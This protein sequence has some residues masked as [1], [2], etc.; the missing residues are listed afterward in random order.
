MKV[1]DDIFHFG[2]VDG[3]LGACTPRI[4]C[5]SIVGEY[6]DEIQ[7]IEIAEFKGS[8]VFYPPAHDKM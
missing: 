3:A 4:L 8:R 7:R 2:I 6:A 5:R 1:D